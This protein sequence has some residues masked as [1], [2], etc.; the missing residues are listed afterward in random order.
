[1][2]RFTLA[3]LLLATAVLPAAAY[4]TRST[5]PPGENL[6]L[7]TPLGWKLSSKSSG[8]VDQPVEFVT[9]NQSGAN[10]TRLITLEIRRDGT[11]LSGYER[12]E[13]NAFR[14]ACPEAQ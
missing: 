7:A 4:S 10:L 1:M 11:S 12:T 5:L 13:M 9:E 3:V 8:N 6:L 14:G 2:T